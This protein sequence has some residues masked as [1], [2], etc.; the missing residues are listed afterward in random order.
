[1]KVNKKI[2]TLDVENFSIGKIARWND[3]VFLFDA[4]NPA[5]VQLAPD[6][7]VVGRLPLKEVKKIDS[8]LFNR[9]SLI[10]V[11]SMGHNIHRWKVTFAPGNP[12]VLSDYRGYPLPVNAIIVAISTLE[13]RYLFLDKNTCMIRV[14]DSDFNEIKTVGSRMGYIQVY[15]DEEEQRLGFEFPEDMAVV[16]DRVVVSDSGNKRLVVVSMAGVEWKQERVF[17]LPEFPY[18]IVFFDKDRI[19]VSDFDRSLMAVSLEYGFIGVEES[20]YPVD[21]F[22]SFSEGRCGLVGSEHGNELVELELPETPIES[23]AEEAGNSRVLMRVKIDG[24]RLEEARGIALEDEKLLPEYAKYTDDK[25]IETQ[26]SGYVEKTVNTVLEKIEPLKK[27]V[28]ALSLEFIKK[29]KAIPGSE[30]KEAARIDKENI[31]HRMFLKLKEYRSLLKTVKDLK[32]VL[33]MHPGPL[34]VFNRLKGARFHDVMQGIE[35]NTKWIETNLTKF[36]ETDL[37]EAVVLYWL[38]TEEEGIVFVDAETGFKYEKLFRD[39]FLLAILNDFY[40]HIAV[41]FLKRHKVEEYISFADREITM[42]PDKLGIFKKFVNRLLHLK[43]YDDVLRMLSK[44]P[45]KNKEDV[46]YFYYR[47]YL[48]KGDGEKA[49]YHLKRELELYSHRIELIPYLIKLNVMDPEEVSA[50]IDKILEKS[51]LS[52]D[53]YLITAKAFLGIHDLEKTGIYI[54]K[55]LEHFPENQ[56]AT[57][58]KLNLLLKRHDLEGLKKHVA[59]LTAPHF[60]LLRSTV[61]FVLEDYEKSW[62]HFKDFV[63]ENP[64]ETTALANLFLFES[65][66]FIDP[67]E[68]G[69]GWLLEMVNRVRF[70][71]YKKEFLTYLSFLKYFRKTGIG[72]G[73]GDVEKFDVG[74]YLSAYSTGILAYDHFFDRAIRLKEEQNWDELFPLVERIL[75]FNPGDKKVFEF[76]DGLVEVVE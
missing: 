23:L 20:D 56:D 14:Y 45:D 60:S 34:A 59:G 64:V 36:D 58:L 25:A 2:I 4:V 40:Y 50:Y 11:D 33:L 73:S 18:K 35:E 44:F 43:K 12:A 52:I 48:A 74:T 10:I 72:S 38:F 65:L 66:N 26:L 62:Y 24:G 70:E 19:V 57:A 61:Y 63:R 8:V 76:L 16:G 13:N 17:K 47:V 75:K 5:A 67:D 3:F 37:L 6:Y 53:T 46:N 22:Q 27:E 68:A 7:N 49:F 9:D 1:M 55:E 29:Y 51:E 30:D 71:S 31:R 21:F 32:N 39:L 42:Y 54:G 15:E 28:S 41:L 69:I